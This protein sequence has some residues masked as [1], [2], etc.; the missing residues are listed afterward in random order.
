MLVKITGAAVQG[1]DAIS[2]VIEVLVGKGFN[3]TIVGLPDTAV[4]ESYPRIMS[5]IRQ[6]GIDYPR[7]DIVI[8][9]SPAD[10]KKEGSAYD[11][12]IAIGILA[13]DEVI[14]TDKLEQYLI[15]GELGLDGKLMPIKGALSITLKA[16]E[17]GYK[18]F[19]LPES[20]AAEAAVVN[21]IEVLG[22]MDIMQ[23]IKFL[24]NEEDITP[25]NIDI[26]KDFYS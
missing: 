7:R 1:I 24:N 23:V 26:E 3:C 16:K 5:A 22:A 11:L 9:L 20:N 13:A 15:M 19:I 6:C 2:V 12:P 21:G 18:G 25:F 4:K 14:S 8:N 10:I 17:L